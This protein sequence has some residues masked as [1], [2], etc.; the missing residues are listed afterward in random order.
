MVFGVLPYYT[1]RLLESFGDMS[2]AHFFANCSI[3]I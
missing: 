3:A 1:Q 2:Q